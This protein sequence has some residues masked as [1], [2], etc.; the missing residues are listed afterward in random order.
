[1]QMYYMH[2]LT[3]HLSKQ[4]AT[5]QYLNIYSLNSNS[6]SVDSD[7]MIEICERI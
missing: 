2:K 4:H 7:L 3:L 6:N 5:C 1:M